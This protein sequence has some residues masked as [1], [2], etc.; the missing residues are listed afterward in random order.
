MGKQ[1]KLT[2]L[3][4]PRIIELFKNENLQILNQLGEKSSSRGR[5]VG[6][7]L[8]SVVTC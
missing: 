6:H 8:T 7:G 1:V 2:T 5:D 4:L 3:D